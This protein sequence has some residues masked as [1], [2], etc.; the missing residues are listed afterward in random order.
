[1]GGSPSARKVERGPHRVVIQRIAIT[2][3]GD[4]HVPAVAQV[5]HQRALK[6]SEPDSPDGAHSAVRHT[7][8]VAPAIAL[9]DGEFGHG[10]ILALSRQICV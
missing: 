8:H 10:V 3:A 5:E 4:Q 9:R 6:L 7:R 1:V 2:A